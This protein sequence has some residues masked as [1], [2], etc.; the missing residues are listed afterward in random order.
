MVIEGAATLLERD[1][2]LNAFGKALTEGRLGGGQVVVVE[3]SAGLG[4]TSLLKAASQIAS[5]AGFT[6]LRARATELERDFAYGCVRQLLETAVATLAVPERDRLFTGAAGLSEPLFS[7]TGIELSSRSADRSLSMLHGLYWLLN[8]L[9]DVGPV[10]LFVDDLHWSDAESLRFLNY[11]TPRLDGLCVVVL[12][13]TRR[14]EKPIDLARL[15]AGPETTVLRPSPLSI[16]ATAALCERRL[17]AKVEPDFAAACREATGG[18]P[19]FLE[20]L[21]GEAAQRRLAASSDEALRVRRIAPA[22]VT[23]AVLLRLSAAPPAAG[24]LV[25]A[26]AVLGDGAS[27]AE[28][29]AMAELAD[30]DAAGAADR[31]VALDILRPA[32]RLEFAHPIVARPCAWTSVPRARQRPRP[33]RPDPR[34]M[35]RDGGTDRRPARR[36]RADRR[37]RSGRAPA[38]G[39]ER[40]A[41]RG[42]PAAAVAWLT[43]ALAEPPAPESSADVLLELGSAELRLGA[44]G[45]VPHLR[46]AVELSRGPEQMATAVRR[47]AIASTIAGHAERAVTALETRSTS[48]NRTIGSWRYCSKERSGRTPCRPDSKPGPGRRDGWS[49]APRVSAGRRPAHASFSPASPAHARGPAKRRAKRLPT[50]RV[51]LPTG[52]SREISRPAWSVSDSPSTFRSD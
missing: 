42:A 6:C 12:A 49:A 52:G 2:E 17:G 43:R 35:R 16:E 37:R 1:D 41:A 23:E 10:A 5:E 47:L 13:S 8:N 48:S 15:M 45:G 38:P 33:W 3:A 25:R 20:A 46:E 50:W 18:N 34:G 27:L 26:V 14:G 22:E 29:A 11:L 31:L 28:A 21:L 40:P 39:G 19:F 36:G 30:E 24:A 32:D 7:P 44:P 9:A 4:K 51:R